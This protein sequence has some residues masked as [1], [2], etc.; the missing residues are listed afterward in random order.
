MHF[1]TRRKKGPSWQCSVLFWLPSKQ[2]KIWHREEQLIVNKE[3]KSLLVEPSTLAEEVE[4]KQVVRVTLE[5]RN[6][7]VEL[8]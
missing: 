4:Y 1:Y 2:R 7:F 3:L 8:V 6:Y 5:Q